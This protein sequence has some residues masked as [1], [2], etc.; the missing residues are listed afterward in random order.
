MEIEIDYRVEFY[1]DTFAITMPFQ[2]YANST[3][4]QCHFNANLPVGQ[5][6]RP[7][8]VGTWEGQFV[9]T[10]ENLAIIRSKLSNTY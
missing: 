4:Y 6:V 10:K 5:V 3:K 2:I 9:I 7:I 8:L 1:A